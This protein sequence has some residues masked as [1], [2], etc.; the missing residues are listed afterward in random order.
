MV[1]EGLALSDIIRSIVTKDNFDLKDAQEY[2]CQI[3]AYYLTGQPNL[4]S[5]TYKWL[6]YCNEENFEY[7]DDR[8]T[9]IQDVMNEL[10][11]K[12]SEKYNKLKD[13]IILEGIRANEFADVRK[14]AKEANQA[15]TKIKEMSKDI[16]EN[17][18]SSNTQSITVL[19]IFTGIAMAFFGGFSLL[20]SAF[21]RLGQ[22]EVVFSELVILVLIIGLIMFDTVYLLLFCASKIN[23]NALVSSK[24]LDCEKCNYKKSCKNTWKARFSFL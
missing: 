22:N 15:L 1:G 24:H 8:L 16:E 4:Y 23:R 12:Y 21:E 10:Y 3:N 14:I 7:L 19:S 13:Y 6:T 20:G 17:K 5:E 11:P 2:A 9:K 18:K